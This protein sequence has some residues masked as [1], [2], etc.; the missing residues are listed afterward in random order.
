MENESADIQ[1]NYAILNP[2]RT[3]DNGRS[4]TDTNGPNYCTVLKKY[5]YA[6]EDA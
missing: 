4:N 1:A 5:Y 3:A 2:N 6:A